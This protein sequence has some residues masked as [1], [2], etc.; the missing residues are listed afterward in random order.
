MERTVFKNQSF[1][2]LLITFL[3]I[4]LCWNLWTFWNSKNLIALIPAI[5]Q[6]IILGLIFTK[7][8]QA[9]LAIKIWAIILIA[10]PSLSI[11]GNTIKVLLGDEILSKIMPLII[12]IL[13]LTAGLYINHFNNTTVELKNIEEFQNQ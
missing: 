12:Q 11:L 3:G 5:I 1:Y 7:N 4:L 10:G 6:I 13:I 2:I 8:K 9:K